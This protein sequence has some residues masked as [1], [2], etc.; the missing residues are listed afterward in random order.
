MAWK[1]KPRGMS[2]VSI[3]SVET[4]L[5]FAKA[6]TAAR[7]KG[8]QKRLA[9]IDHYDSLGCETSVCTTSMI[10]NA[11]GDEISLLPLIA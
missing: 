2:Y 5:I 1:G 9:D 7:D 3:K 8:K 11:V 4:F 10:D 6:L